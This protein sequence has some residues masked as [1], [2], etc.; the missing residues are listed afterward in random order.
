MQYYS[1]IYINGKCDVY[2]IESTGAVT[3]LNPRLDLYNHSP[4]GFGWGYAGSGA[5]QLALALLA[6]CLKDDKK[7]L[8]LH[9]EFKHILI[10]TLQ[11]EAPWSFSVSYIL[12]AC[13]Y[14][15]LQDEKSD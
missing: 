15:S 9:Q 14:L 7:A 6:D 13:D 8:R 11:K 12:S 10:V 3:C 2:R 1:G 4:T 5:A